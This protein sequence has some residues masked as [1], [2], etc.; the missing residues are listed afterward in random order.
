MEFPSSWEEAFHC[1]TSA[2][3][4]NAKWDKITIGTWNVN[5]LSPHVHEIIALEADVVALQEVRIGADSV[6]GMRSTFKQYGYNLY[7][8]DLPNY[9]KQGHNKNSIHLEQSI[10][11]VAF[12]I[13]THIPVQEICEDSMSKWFHK[14]RFLAIKIFI[15]QRWVTC[16]NVYAPTQNSA[17]FLDDLLPALEAQSHNNCILFGD[18]NADSR[19]GQFIQS[20]IAAGWFPLTQST[21]FDFFTYRHSNGNTSCIDIVAVTDLLKE[22]IAPIQ[23]T[24]VLDK[25]HSFIHTSIHNSFQ[26]KPTWEIYHQVEFE[27]KDDCDD[28]WQKILVSHIPRLTNTSID[29]DWEVWCQSFQKIHNCKGAVLGLQPRFRMREQFKNSKLHNQLG[30]AI[31]N[32]DW[33]Q[34]KD[35]LSKLQQISKN[36]IKKWRM[37]IQKKGQPQHTWI[38]NLFKWARA[39]SP[40]IPSCVASLKYGRDGFT[41]CLHDS[42]EEITDYFENVYK[43]SQVVPPEQTV[44]QHSHLYDA[45]QVLEITQHLRTVLSKAD[46]SKVP[47]LDGI[48]IAHLKQI[49]YTATLFLAH[50]FH[51]AILQQRVP[52]VWLNCKMTCIP[53]KQGKTSV[54][55]LRP[56]TITPVCY[57]IFCKTLLLMHNEA[58]QNISEHSV[59]GVCGRSAFHA[60]L[61]AALMC[62]ATWRLD[63]LFRTTVQG[64]AI[65]TEKFF[66]NVPPDKA[67][68]SLIRIGV[69]ASAVATWQFMIKNI[70]RFAS[71]NGAVAKKGFGASVGIPQGDPLSMLAA[72]TLLGEWTYEIPHDEVFAK[73]F[74]DDRLMLSS[75]S[76]QLQQAFFTTQIWDGSFDFKTEAKT[77]AFGNNAEADNLWWLDGFEV[78]RQKQVVY[79]GVPLPLKNISASDFFKPILHDCYMILNKMVRSH[80]TH[81]NAVTVVARKIMP[82]ICYP[83]TVVRPTKAQIDNLRSKIFEATAFRKCQTQAAHSVF[84]ELT[85]LFDPES[86]MVYHNMR[87]WRQVFIQAPLLAQQLK[88]MLEQ[89]NSAQ[90]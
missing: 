33:Q 29:E 17:P 30:Q 2:I 34:Q 47:G 8:S 77:V 67:C 76:Q 86:A 38:K 11:G 74:V 79:L 26:Q 19:N 41:N 24:E 65:D 9:K 35:I 52:L 56:L 84:C 50:I 16:Y 14:G 7:F 71:L 73:V 87:F 32:Q 51:K 88:N 54:K 22:T 58:Q 25:G 6:H 44:D 13:R 42:L 57:R 72:A 4:D 1:T 55:D 21:N 27:I 5:A 48:E 37:K 70:R 23:A 39:P 63:P 43:S 62:E 12:A 10:P 28:E 3:H 61:P 49:P 66:D 36:Q 60:W 45:R 31:Q 81:D 83:C 90:T 69:P 53:K 46:A 20:C 89:S 59:G 82:S 78:K 18:I 68:E 85:H 40:P 64:I 80:I 15:Q 75:S